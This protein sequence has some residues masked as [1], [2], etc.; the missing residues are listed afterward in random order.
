LIDASIGRFLDAR[1]TL[2]RLGRF[3]S[4]VEALNL[5]YLVVRNVEGVLVLAR[6]DLV[7]LPAANASARAAFEIG[8]K[9]AW[10]VDVADPFEREA[11]WL[12]HVQEEERVHQRLASHA[13]KRGV[14]VDE[15]TAV[16]T[17]IRTFREAV[18]A[19]MPPHV[20]ILQRNPSMADMLES[21]GSVDLYGSYISL[22][23]YLH[24]GHSATR[25]FR[26]DLGADKEIG[27]FIAASDWHLPLW[28]VWI[29]LS[30]FGRTVLTRLGGDCASFVTPAEEE[31]IRIAIQRVQRVDPP[32][33]VH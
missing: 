4:E 20:A 24:G 9:S 26:R 12:V 2:P 28:V 19:R 30:A 10:M 16:H 27:E 29:S 21:L 22:S 13:R 7:L 18:S 6:E 14:S 33:Q 11:R 32:E 5:L 25:L 3:E 31:A 1:E 17:Q 23:Q 15:I 8:A